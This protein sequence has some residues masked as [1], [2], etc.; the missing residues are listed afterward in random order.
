[1]LVV[2]GFAIHFLGTVWQPTTISILG[3]VEKL[4]RAGCVFSGKAPIDEFGL[5]AADM[6]SHPEAVLNPWRST[7][8]KENGVHS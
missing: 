7:D 2:V 6:V 8:A 3:Q 1:M 4:S 5:G